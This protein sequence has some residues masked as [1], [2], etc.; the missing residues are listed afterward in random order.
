MTSKVQLSSSS[1]DDSSSGPTREQVLARAVAVAVSS[2]EEASQ[3]PSISPRSVASEHASLVKDTI[4]A[5]DVGAD[6]SYNTLG[7]QPVTQFSAEVLEEVPGC[8]TGSYDIQSL[9]CGLFA[10][11]DKLIGEPHD[12]Y[13]FSNTLDK[14]KAE[15]GKKPDFRK[16]IEWVCE[17]VIKNPAITTC[18]TLVVLS[19]TRKL[20]DVKH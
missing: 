8:S 4:D 17:Q 16:I 10:H 9:S 12:V 1:D 19:D 6:N 5:T 2:T 3:C 18:N 15:L 20:E 14:Q 7:A 13:K 11:Y